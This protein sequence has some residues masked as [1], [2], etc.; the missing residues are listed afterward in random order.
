LGW[1][2]EHVLEAIGMTSFIAHSV[3]LGAVSLEAVDFLLG[4]TESS[5][6]LDHDIG[7][8]QRRLLKTLWWAL[9]RRSLGWCLEVR[10]TRTV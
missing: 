3:I 10:L 9:G 8:V 7:V 6:K 2:V 5:L 4:L 1:E